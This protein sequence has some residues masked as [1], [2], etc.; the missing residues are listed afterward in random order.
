MRGDQTQPTPGDRYLQC[1]HVR[2]DARSGFASAHILRIHGSGPSL[3]RFA[4]GA[5][6]EK[7]VDLAVRWV[8]LCDSCYGRHASGDDGG[9]IEGR[10]HVWPE[11]AEI[12]YLENN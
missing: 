1:R 4:P 9:V 12:V 6:P 11:G 7:G 8:V 2:G 3:R 5:P 10:D